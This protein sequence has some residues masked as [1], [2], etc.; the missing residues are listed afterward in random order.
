MK[1]GFEAMRLGSIIYFVPFFFVLNPALI[2]R[3]PLGEVMLVLVTA[4]IG[5]WLISSGLQGYLYGVGSLDGGVAAIPG[6]ALLIMGGIILA[7][8][9]NEAI[10]PFSHLEINSLA[11]ALALLGVAMCWFGRRRPGV[12]PQP[13]S[14]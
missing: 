10:I 3:G 9:A 5:I 12:A 2:G 7:L 8:P 1:T 6:R 4:I 11:L 14:G 13:S